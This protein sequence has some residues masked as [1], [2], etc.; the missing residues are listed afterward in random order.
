MS[1]V[2]RDNYS[3]SF[4]QFTSTACYLSDLAQVLGKDYRTIAKILSNLNS[5]VVQPAI[6]IQYSPEQIKFIFDQLGISEANFSMIQLDS[7][8]RKLKRL[9]TK[10]NS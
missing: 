8:E 4:E 9:S 2:K 6:G 10:G 5:K 7:L 1:R 3:L